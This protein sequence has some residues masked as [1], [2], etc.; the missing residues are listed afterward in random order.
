MESSK[1]QATDRQL[2]RLGLLAQLFLSGMFTFL[3]VDL[4]NLFAFLS[5]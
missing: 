4:N 5:I 2:F 1:W 3:V